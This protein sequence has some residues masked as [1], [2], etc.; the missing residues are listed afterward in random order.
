MGDIFEADRDTNGFPDVALNASKNSQEL[1][2]FNVYP[3]AATSDKPIN[4]A[5]Q[6]PSDF[7]NWETVSISQLK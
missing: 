6:L 2:I 3:N 7:R 5:F 4:L 1:I